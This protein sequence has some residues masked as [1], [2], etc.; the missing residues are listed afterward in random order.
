MLETA[1]VT[2]KDLVYDLGCGDGRIVI[3]A[4]KSYGARGVGIDIDPER[5]KE[6]NGQRRQGR[7]RRP[8]QVHPGRP[9]RDRS[10]AGNGRHALPARIP[11]SEAPAQARERVEARNAHRFARLQHGSMD[12]RPGAERRGPPGIPVDDSAQGRPRRRAASSADRARLRTRVRPAFATG[13]RCACVVVLLRSDAGSDARNRGSRSP[14]RALRMDYAFEQ[15]LPSDVGTLKRLLAVFGE[16]FNE[17]A[18]LPGRRS[19]RRL[20]GVTAVEAAC[21]RARCLER[22]RR[23]GRRARRIRARQVRTRPAR[24]LHL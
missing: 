24:N 14:N 20:P 5:I 2:A 21:H 6:A 13:R 3:E 17:V 22:R 4:A 1:G 19:R 8:R 15:L 7:G 10:A 9:V 23:S 11:Q 18:D 12:T 16:A